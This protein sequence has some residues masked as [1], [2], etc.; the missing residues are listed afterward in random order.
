M[1]NLNSK[2]S[3]ALGLSKYLATGS[4]AFAFAH[5]AFAQDAKIRVVAAE[6]F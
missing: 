5:A 1:K 4:A 2:W 3:R 6:N